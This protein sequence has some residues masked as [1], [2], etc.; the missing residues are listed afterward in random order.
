[1][2]VNVQVKSPS[3]YRNSRSY[4]LLVKDGPCPVAEVYTINWQGRTTLPVFNQRSKADALRQILASGDDWKLRRTSAGEL[5]SVLA[6]FLR[7]IQRVALDPGPEQP[8][9]HDDGYETTSDVIPLESRERF[10]ELLATGVS[11]PGHVAKARQEERRRILSGVERA[12][13][14]LPESTNKTTSETTK[15]RTNR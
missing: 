3:R 14:P 7:N 5:V 13:G 12:R 1:M 15:R 6:T 8:P 11:L 9:V 2:Q 10:M 4:W